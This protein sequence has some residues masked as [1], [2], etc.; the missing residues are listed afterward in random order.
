[1]PRPR[2]LALHATFSVSLHRSGRFTSVE[3][4]VDVGP[5]QCGQFSAETGTNATSQIIRGT[6][7]F[8]LLLPFAPPGIVSILEHTSQICTR[9]HGSS[10]REST[11]PAVERSKCKCHPTT[12][13]EYLGKC[14][15]PFGIAIAP[16]LVPGVALSLQEDA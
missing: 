2:T 3:V 8:M 5:R 1:M 13:T 14:D 7:F 16:Y 12:C 15:L 10:Q 11:F 6:E 4:P 9:L